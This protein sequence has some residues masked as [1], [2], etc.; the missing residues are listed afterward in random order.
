MTDRLPPPVC[1]RCSPASC[2]GSCARPPPGGSGGSP[3]RYLEDS[4]SPRSVGYLYVQGREENLFPLLRNGLA[5]CRNG[6]GSAGGAPEGGEGGGVSLLLVRARR[7]GTVECPANLWLALT[8]APYKCVPAS[9]CRREDCIR[10]AGPD[11]G[12]GVYTRGATANR[13]VSR[14]EPI[15]EAGLR[16]RDVCRTVL[17]V[18]EE[19]REQF[20]RW[21]VREFTKGK[22][23]GESERV[24]PVRDARAA[25][26]EFLQKEFGF[27]YGLESPHPVGHDPEKFHPHLNFLWVRRQG[28]GFLLP[29][30]LAALKKEWARILGWDGPVVVNHSYIRA[31]PDRQ[32][33]LAQ[34]RHAYRYFTRPFP[35]WGWWRGRAVVWLGSYPKGVVTE[36][37]PSPCEDCGETEHKVAGFI[38]EY[39]HSLWLSLGRPSEMLESNMVQDRRDIATMQKGPLVARAPPGSSVA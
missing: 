6:S 1:L 21:K 23:K 25:V 35:G 5:V 12:G 10:C 38:S 29:E 31:R 14:I 22:R 3:P 34:R 24:G 37:K 16:G 7:G 28:T 20:A 26:K 30:Q 9:P 33:A 2:A 18:P 15:F 32:K 13:R 39:V 27:E 36:E 17:T 4:S 11:Q 8:C 19:C